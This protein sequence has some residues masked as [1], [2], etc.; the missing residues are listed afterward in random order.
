MQEIMAE[1]EEACN[2]QLNEFANCEIFGSDDRPLFLT[3]SLSKKVFK[4]YECFGGESE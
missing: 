1:E 3:E 4:R 2:D